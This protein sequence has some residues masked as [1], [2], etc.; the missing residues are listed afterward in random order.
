MDQSY[1][2]I[3]PK[4]CYRFQPYSMS[5]IDFSSAGNLGHV[6][7]VLIFDN[8]SKYDQIGPNI[9]QIG[10]NWSQSGVRNVIFI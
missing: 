1:L 6:V 2:R 5:F 3:R 9:Y 10:L 8:R 7:S 4:S